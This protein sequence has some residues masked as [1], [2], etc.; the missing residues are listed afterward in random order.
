[1]V[2]GWTFALN[3]LPVPPDEG[4]TDV[5]AALRLTGLE[6]APGQSAADKLWS[7]DVPGH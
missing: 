4:P 1:V 3:R 2:A 5:G 7:D 6:S